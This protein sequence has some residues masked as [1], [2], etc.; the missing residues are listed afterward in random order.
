MKK[1][2]VIYIL[3]LSSFT[4][5]FA[6]YTGFNQRK[7]GSGQPSIPKAK[8]DTLGTKKNNNF[9]GY[10]YYGSSEDLLASLDTLSFT[11]A[12]DTLHVLVRYNM[13]LKYLK[14]QENCFE[15]VKSYID[16]SWVRE[17]KKEIDIYEVSRYRRF[18][19]TIFT[20]TEIW[21]KLNKEEKIYF[22]DFLIDKYIPRSIELIYSTHLRR[23]DDDFNRHKAPISVYGPS[24][25]NMNMLASY[26]YAKM[27]KEYNIMEHGANHPASYLIYT[28]RMFGHEYHVK[29]PE[30][31]LA[32]VK[33]LR[34]CI[35]EVD[36]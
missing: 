25:G 2:I 26:F 12:Y 1:Q 9:G 20:S 6:Q 27:F 35:S 28:G 8:V 24:D 31:F 10:A 14:K 23:K 30:K 3:L 16:T 22:L 17:E 29:D 33:I 7:L 5:L 34:K 15:L 11:E 32:N 4:F 13:L 18:L 19:Q 21:E 36:S